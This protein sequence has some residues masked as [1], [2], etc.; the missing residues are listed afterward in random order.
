MPDSKLTDNDSRARP[1]HTGPRRPRKRSNAKAEPVSA[2]ETVQPSA[3]SESPKP[4]PS[5]NR[6]PRPV[7]QAPSSRPLAETAGPDP[8]VPL[9]DVRLAIGS[10]GSPHGT[11]G[12]LRLRLSTDDPDHLRQIK[13]VY[14][15][16]EQSPRTLLSVRFHQG[17]GLIRLSGVQSPD[18]ARALL[19]Q[20]VRI[21][22]KDARPLQPGEFYYYQVIGLVAHDESGAVI[23]TVT[24]IMETGANDV[25]VITPPD[26]AKE[27]LLPNIPDVVLEINSAER[28][29]VVRPLVYWES[30]TESE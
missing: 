13:R 10:I 18:D 3:P 21:S 23:G 16:D 8:D 2:S 1:V 11:E 14:V 26:G 27:I 24:D 9:R 5:R 25:F 29:L 4:R 12:E 7:H 28:R 22:G 20:S 6:P 15:G 19:G 17:L 30:P